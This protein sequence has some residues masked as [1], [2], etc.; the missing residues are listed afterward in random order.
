MTETMR[1]VVIDQPGPP[2]VLQIRELPIPQAGAGQVLIRVRAFGLNRSE[3]HFRT[4]VATSGTF[5]RVPG[6]EATG[7]VAAAPG[8]EFTPGEQVV[9]MMGGMGRVFDG[10]YA[11]YVV[12]PAGQVTA[13]R[14]DLRW[15]QLGAVP[16]MLQ[17]AYGSLTVGVQAQSGDT[18]LIRGGTS[19]VGLALAV[20]AKNHGL[21][22]YA[23]TRREQARAQLEQLGVDHVLIDDG[24][25]ADQ[26]R[27]AA[28]H[29]VD[30]AV[31]LVGVNTLKDTLR[32]VRS[33]GTVCFTGMLSDQWTIAEFSPMDWLPNGVR[34]TALLRRG[35]R[36]HGRGPAGLP[37][38]R[39]V[40]CSHHP[41]GTGV[42]ARPDRPGAPRHG[43]RDRR[44]QRR[45][46]DLTA[47]AHS[48]P[49]PSD[50][51]RSTSAYRDG[52]AQF[53]CRLCALSALAATSGGSIRRDGN[54]T[55]HTPRK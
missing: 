20:L 26:I 23:T 48:A 38:H 35:N 34:L 24:A 9:T 50:S 21:T 32:A 29:G 54:R 53:A 5:P 8:G 10:G 40:R 42:P 7:V 36:S 18:L 44:R 39:C 55:M 16:E 22:V 14:S 27:D 45:R 11:E 28:P 52:V 15:E 33:G 3:L 2:E 30:G 49:A 41:D 46:A 31:E 6:I 51:H 25:I 12:V 1:A 37:R 47:R 13:F 4:G 43:G 19:S 17:T